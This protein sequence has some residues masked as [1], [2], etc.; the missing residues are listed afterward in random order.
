MTILYITLHGGSLK[1]LHDIRTHVHDD[2]PKMLE[3]EGRAKMAALKETQFYQMPP[4]SSVRGSYLN[5]VL[6]H[7][8]NTDDSILSPVFR[9]S[10]TTAKKVRSKTMHIIKLINQ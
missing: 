3:L 9:D 2:G 7:A 5:H 8:A 6:P 1:Y 10:I 4:G